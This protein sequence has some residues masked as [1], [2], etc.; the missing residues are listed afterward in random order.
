MA[1][2]ERRYHYIY[3]ITC[4]ITTRFYVGMHSTDNL[5]DNYMGSGTRLGHSKRK[6]GIENHVIEILEFLPNRSSL[7]DREREIVNEQFIQDPLC[8]NLQLGG[9]GGFSSEEHQLKCSFAGGKANALKLKTNPEH[10]KNF[11]TKISVIKK[12]MFKEGVLN[13]KPLDWTGR[14]HSEESK[15]K[16]R[17]YASQRIGDKNSQFGTCWITNGLENSKIKKTETIP[18]GWKLGRTIIKNNLS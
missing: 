5:E 2:K 15:Q 1:R 6:H 7:K 3:K 14:K 9:G 18:D 13:F 8:M 12:N 17:E 11:G 10:F 16:M 4:K